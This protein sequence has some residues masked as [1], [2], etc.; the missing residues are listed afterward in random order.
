MTG[1]ERRGLVMVLT[2]NGK[3]KTTS[4]FGQALRA[5]GH[6]ARVLV[7]QFMKGSPN[8]GEFLAAEKYLAGHL[9]VEQHGRDSFVHKGNLEPEDLELA[10]RGLERARD[11]LAR[12]HFGLV[13]LDEVNVAVDFGLL[14]LSDVEEALAGRRPDVD[15]LLTGRYAPPALVQAADLV[16]EVLDI[17]HHY[18][19]GVSAREGI[20]F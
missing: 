19:D 7:I 8:Y 16:S 2:G 12:G 9:V 6:G 10:R 13:V 11:E 20:E 4:A 17:K 5:I 14:A 18:A 3:G 15:V 1:E